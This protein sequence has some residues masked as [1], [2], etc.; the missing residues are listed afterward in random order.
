MW[1]YFTILYEIMWSCLSYWIPHSPH[2]LGQLEFL[3]LNFRWILVLALVLRAF[4]HLHL[5]S[6][7]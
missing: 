3:D 6:A 2:F 5:G 7:E 4:L 1:S